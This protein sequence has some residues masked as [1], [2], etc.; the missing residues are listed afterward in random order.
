D[1]ATPDPAIN[2]GLPETFTFALTSYSGTEAYLIAKPE[3]TPYYTS[4]TTLGNVGL[5]GW[6]RGQGT[7][8]SFSTTCGPAQLADENFG[9]LFANVMRTA[10]VACYANCDGSTIAPV[11][12]VNDF[13]CFMSRFAS[14]DGYANC[15]GSTIAPVLNAN[16]FLCFQS[17]F[18]EGCQ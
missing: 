17:H 16:D 11:L 4:S 2:A 3:A 1:Q 14:G 7:V 18:A 6:A 12:D 15:D 10:P 9:V 13:I 8:F 5:A